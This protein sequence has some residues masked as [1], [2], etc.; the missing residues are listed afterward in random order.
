MAKSKEVLDW[1]GNP[2]EGYSGRFSAGVGHFLMGEIEEDG[3]KYLRMY[4]EGGVPGDRLALEDCYLCITDESGKVLYDS[5]CEPPP[6]AVLKPGYIGYEREK[7]LKR[8]FPGCVFSKVAS[9]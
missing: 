5:R 4:T 7:Q 3:K 2:I 6:D 9:A 1:Y 8:Y